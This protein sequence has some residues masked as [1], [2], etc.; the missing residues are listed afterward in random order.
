ME[1]RPSAFNLYPY[2]ENRTGAHAQ[3]SY[4]WPKFIGIFSSAGLMLRKRLNSMNELFEP[5]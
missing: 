1:P 3:R 2:S 4:N 5:W